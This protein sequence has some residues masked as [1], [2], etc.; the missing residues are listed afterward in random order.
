MEKVLIIDDNPTD[1]FVQKRMLEPKYE[2]KVAQDPYEAEGIIKEW[3]PDIVV[4]DY[5]MPKMNGIQAIKFFKE[6]VKYD[7]IYLMLTGLDD[8]NIA[9]EAIRGGAYDYIV[10]P[11]VSE[12]FNHKIRNCINYR[13]LLKGETQVWQKIEP[14]YLPVSGAQIHLEFRL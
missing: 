2:V 6:K 12:V 7:G 10:K 3:Q 5:A 13:K 1:R 14:F 11:L 9:T 8:I 4:I